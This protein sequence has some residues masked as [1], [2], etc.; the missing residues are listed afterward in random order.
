MIQ[1]LEIESKMNT[2]R[3]IG[4]WELDISF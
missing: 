1:T 3:R 2:K 4:E